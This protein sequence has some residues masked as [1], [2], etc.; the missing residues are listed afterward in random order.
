[1]MSKQKVLSKFTVLGWATF[2]AILGRMQPAGLWMD[3][4]VW[5]SS[6][7]S[8]TLPS[9]PLSQQHTDECQSARSLPARCFQSQG[10]D[11]G[12][13][14]TEEGVELF[15]YHVTNALLVYKQIRIKFHS[16]SNLS[17][18]PECL[19][20]PPWLISPTLTWLSRTAPMDFKEP[21]PLGGHAALAGPEYVSGV[22]F[23]QERHVPSDSI[24]VFQGKVL[25]PEHCPV[26]FNF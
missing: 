15:L 7:S 10:Y 5:K 9:C 22:G 8:P 26:T 12:P 24:P 25:I 11:G 1:M 14:N 20:W 3:T 2:I 13:P 23:S 19:F 17:N 6:S 4:P 21:S 18:V 16:L